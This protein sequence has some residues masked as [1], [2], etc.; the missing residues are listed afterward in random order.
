M[1]KQYTLQAATLIG[2]IFLSNLSLAAEIKPNKTFSTSQSLS[3]ISDLISPRKVLRS[4][5]CLLICVRPPGRPERCSYDRGVPQCA[6]L[7]K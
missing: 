6:A 4:P 3:L 2:T 7:N 5:T 1:K